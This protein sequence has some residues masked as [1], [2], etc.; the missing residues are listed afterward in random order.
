VTYDSIG[1]LGSNGSYRSLSV[2]CYTTYSIDV[3]EPFIVRLKDEADLSQEWLMGSNCKYV[4]TRGLA[5]DT[6]NFKYYVLVHPL[7]SN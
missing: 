5:Q 1:I 3:E 6:A 7:A 4:V 2:Q